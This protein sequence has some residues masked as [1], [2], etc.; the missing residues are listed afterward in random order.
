MGLVAAPL[1]AFLLRRANQQKEAEIAYQASL[2]DHEKR[3]YTVQ[4]LHDLGICTFSSF[5]LGGISERG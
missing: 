2:P 3:V 1:Y 4:E 5:G